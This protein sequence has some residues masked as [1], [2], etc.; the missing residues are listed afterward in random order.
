[1]GQSGVNKLVVLKALH[2]ETAG[3]AEAQLRF[4]DEARVAAQLNHA[5]V[6][7]TYEVGTEGDRSVIV[8]E[9]LEGHTLNQLARRAKLQGETIPLGMQLC[10]IINALEG[11]HYAHEFTSYD[12]VLLQL[13]HR[14]VSPQNIF[15]TYD[16]Q[17]KVLDFGIAKITGASSQTQM[18][19]LKG[20]IAYMSPE[21]MRGEHLDRRADIFSIGC[22]LWAIATGTKLWKDAPDIE[23]MRSVIRGEI[24]RVEDANPNC[25]PELTRI[26]SKAVAPDAA[27]R[28]ATALELQ[29]DLQAYCARLGLSVSQKELGNY[30]SRSFAA[31]RADMRAQ[32]ERE[33]S[34][35][36][37]EDPS[38]A[39]FAAATVSAVKNSASLDAS[40]VNRSPL[41]AKNPFMSGAQ[42]LAA[43]A[44]IGVGL[45]LANH[46]LTD[47]SPPPASPASVAAAPLAQPTAESLIEETNTADKKT[48]QILFRVTP[49]GAVLTVDG[50]A[51]PPGITSQVFPADDAVHVLKAEAPGLPAIVREFTTS[52]DDT[53]EVHLFSRVQPRTP[54]VRPSTARVV[55][56]PTHAAPPPPVVK[57]GSDGPSKPDCDSPSFFDA[58][59]IKRFRAECL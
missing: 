20:K 44:A 46:W 11:I 53:L 39:T 26:V 55:P 27:S 10:V 29:S 59:G 22:M 40:L 45:L 6:V 30:V 32:V 43:F 54:L 41:G 58:N 9:Y 57:S 50:R 31:I 18:G 19:T 13:V 28:Y 47:R 16:G 34:R 36:M 33:V 3:D 23:I 12:G 4:L 8:M 35:I 52:R 49:T 48:V 15:V 25:D 21:Q 17:V 37:A 38:T 7:Q 24:P 56:A 2:A 5:N 51:L 42:Y 14:D 1:V